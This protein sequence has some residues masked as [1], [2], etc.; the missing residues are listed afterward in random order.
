MVFVGVALFTNIRML[1]PDS[2]LKGLATALT[3]TKHVWLHLHEVMP[4]Y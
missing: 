1:S 4:R 2:F 3:V